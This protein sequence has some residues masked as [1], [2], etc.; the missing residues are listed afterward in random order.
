VKKTTIAAAAVAL[1]IPVGVQALN[2]EPAAA[3]TPYWIKHYAYDSGYGENTG[4]KVRCDNWRQTGLTFDIQAGNAAGFGE[5]IC[6][7]GIADVYTRVN[8]ELHCYYGNTIGWGK[9]FDTNVW[10][11][12]FETTNFG[13]YC[14]LQRD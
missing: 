1:T 9:K 5:N 3:W 13:W 8:E 12:V 10:H 14:V 2:V 4:I 7:G 11:H 6:S